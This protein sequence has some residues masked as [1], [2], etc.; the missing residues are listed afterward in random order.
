MNLFLHSSLPEVIHQQYRDGYITNVIVPYQESSI[1][2]LTSILKPILAEGYLFKHIVIKLPSLD[3]SNES[4]SKELIEQLVEEARTLRKLSRSITFELPYNA[5]GVA[6]NKRFTSIGLHTYVTGVSSVE[7]ALILSQNAPTLLA[8]SSSFFEQYA[9][10]LGNHFSEY[11]LPIK[12]VVPVNCQVNARNS[13]YL[14]GMVT[15]LLFTD[16]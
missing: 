4:P 2:E 1:E 7:N 8:V 6:L 12:F 10:L 5:L 16:Y 14:Y 9:E 3:Y 13:K 15:N 11:L